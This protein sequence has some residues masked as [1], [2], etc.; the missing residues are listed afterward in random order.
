MSYLLDTNVLLR[1]LEV[2]HPH[3]VPA[4]QA[5]ERLARTS[6]QLFVAP[7][8]LIEFWTVATRPTTARGLGLTTAQAL[9]ELATFEVGFAMTV[10]SP[11]VYA[12]WRRL[13]VAYKVSGLPS[14]D[15]R[16]VAVMRV[17]RI[18][19]ILTFNGTDFHRYASGEG[20]HIVDPATVPE[21]PAV[22]NTP[23]S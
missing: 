4:R 18:E 19:N 23:I 14:Y 9:S 11:A 5:I 8:N 7:Q 22:P 2:G 1:S 10:D 15:A 21:S 3:H 12:A 13:I 20:I 17:H 6:E 16:L